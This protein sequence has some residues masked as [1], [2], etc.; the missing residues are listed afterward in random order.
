MRE[1]LAPSCVQTLMNLPSPRAW[2]H[3]PKARRQEALFDESLSNARGRATVAETSGIP[4]LASQALDPLGAYAIHVRARRRRASL[5]RA[6]ELEQ[7]DDDV[8]IPFSASAVEAMILAYTGRI[9]EAR[10]R[11]PAVR[12]RCLERGSDRNMMVVSEIRRA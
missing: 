7:V 4:G 2:V 8:P 9:D 10:S 5:T 3:S 11:M 12:E 6:L 1:D